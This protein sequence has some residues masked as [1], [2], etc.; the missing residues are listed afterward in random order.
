VGTLLDLAEQQG[1]KLECGCRAG[2]CGS[3]VV[4]I[5][6]GS[7]EYLDSH[8]APPEEGSCLTCIARP[9]SDLVLEA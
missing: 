4:A 1:V 6:S 9:K 3:C 8:S 2:S 5:K 7:V